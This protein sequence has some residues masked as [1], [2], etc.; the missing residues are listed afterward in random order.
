MGHGV[1]HIDMLGAIKKDKL[2]QIKQ[3]ITV[4]FMLHM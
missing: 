2:W 3:G 1:W 4:P